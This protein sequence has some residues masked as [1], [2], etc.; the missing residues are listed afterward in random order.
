MK[1][2]MP[3]VVDHDKR[4]MSIV[5]AYLEL[6]GERGM[7]EANSRALAQKMGISNSLLWRYFDD[8]NQLIEQA[9]RTITEDTNARIQRSVHGRCGVEAF[10]RALDEI[11]PI[12]YESRIEA[13]IA[14]SFWG[15]TVAT[16][17]Q[18]PVTLH[19]IGEWSQLLSSFLE[20]AI[21]RGE[22]A[23]TTPVLAIV[24]MAL[25]TGI[26]AQV[27]FALTLSESIAK[28]LRNSVHDMLSIVAV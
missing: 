14:V 1:Q 25:A 20:Q 7:P 22:I 13:K 23:A 8:M 19:E 9:Y 18:A 3:K 16:R 11:F 4:R 15:L 27:E 24:R 12:S 28:D 21:E 6:V 26:Q 5:R 2:Q 17:S 10:N